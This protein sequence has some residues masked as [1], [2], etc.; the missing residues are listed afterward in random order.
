RGT[1]VSASYQAQINDLLYEAAV[2]PHGASKVALLE[3]AVRLADSHGD[4]GLGFDV[5][6]DLVNACNFSG[7]PEKTLVAFSWR[8]AQVDRSPEEFDEN[9]L[10]WEYKWIATLLPQYPQITRTQIL[11]M[12]DDLKRRYL[13]AGSSLRP[14]YSLEC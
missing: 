13:H 6:K 3:E 10:L 2:L 7:F 4:I 5:R 14:V 8:L 1:T 11:E 9:D 12:L